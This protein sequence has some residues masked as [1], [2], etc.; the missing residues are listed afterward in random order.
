MRLPAAATP[1]CIMGPSPFPWGSTMAF[2]DVDPSVQVKSAAPSLSRSPRQ[3]LLLLPLQLCP[4]N[5][6][7]TC[8]RL[9]DDSTALSQWHRL[10]GLPQRFAGKEVLKGGI[11]LGKNEA[12]MEEELQCWSSDWLNHSNYELLFSVWRSWLWRNQVLSWH[13][14]LHGS[15]THT[16]EGVTCC[17]VC[18]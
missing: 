5:V 18:G 14:C 11:K 15:W 7:K 1:R 3:L 4:L 17:K 9:G 6:L 2:N 12:E 10:D 8:G 16:S 13:C